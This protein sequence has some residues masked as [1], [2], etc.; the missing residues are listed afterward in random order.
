MQEAEA[1]TWAMG[2]P[3]SYDEPEPVALPTAGLNGLHLDA[4]LKLMNKLDKCA[5]EWGTHVIGQA[6]FELFDGNGDGVT[7]VVQF[8]EDLN[9]HYLARVES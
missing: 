5:E 3:K 1:G 2:T 6:K 9:L 7:I 4:L 8:N